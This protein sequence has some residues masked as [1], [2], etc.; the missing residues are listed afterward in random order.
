MGLFQLIRSVFSYGDAQP[1]RLI[2]SN[3]ALPQIL[4]A[5]ESQLDGEEECVEPIWGWDRDMIQ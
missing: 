4:D 2:Q 3:R 5:F 1:A